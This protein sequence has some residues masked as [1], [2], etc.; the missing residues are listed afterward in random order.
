MKFK[1]EDNSVQNVY[2]LSSS[3]KKKSPATL[4]ACQELVS[5]TCIIMVAHLISKLYL[6]NFKKL[7][8]LTIPCL[9]PH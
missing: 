2:F 4:E 6:K 9:P 1:T 8:F 5:S 3:W 7:P